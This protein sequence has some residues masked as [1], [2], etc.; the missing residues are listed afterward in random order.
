MK[1]IIPLLL[2]VALLSGCGANQKMHREIEQRLAADRE[3][4]AR[5]FGHDIHD[6]KI[7]SANVTTQYD[8]FN[9]ATQYNGP[10][11]VPHGWNEPT[12]RL[13]AVHDE[14]DSGTSYAI[15]VLHTYRGSWRFYN[16]ALDSDRNVL[17]VLSLLR[18][19]RECR[20]SSCEHIESYMI[21]IS[22]HY[23]EDRRDRG[24]HLRTVGSGP[25][26]ASEF[27]IPSGYVQ[28]FLASVP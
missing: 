1:H 9:K 21:K 22:R 17:P 18:E 15:H 3:A 12:V 8:D 20:Q 7:V 28:G 13:V 10:E 19:T 27:K 26:A 25:A 23:L 14:R 2:G 4:K 24:L 16:A 5:W 6:P 11:A